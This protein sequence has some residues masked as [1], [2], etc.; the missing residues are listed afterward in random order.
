MNPDDLSPA[1]PPQGVLTMRCRENTS[2]LLENPLQQRGDGGVEILRDLPQ[3]GDCQIHLAALDRAHM[4]AVDLTTGGKRLLRDPFLVTE[5][6]DPLTQLL[7]IR[8]HPSDSRG[9]LRLRPQCIIAQFITY[10]A[11]MRRAATL[12]EL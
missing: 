11:D 1:T 9:M 7:L 5:F 8:L 2:E 10:I 4:H 3:G 12:R 6:G